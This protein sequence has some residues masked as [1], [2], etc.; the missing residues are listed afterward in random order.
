LQAFSRRGEKQERENVRGK[1]G[2][3]LMNAL[4][5]AVFPGVGGTVETTSRESYKGAFNE[6]FP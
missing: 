1:I 5:G 2:P 3:G 4:T 6:R